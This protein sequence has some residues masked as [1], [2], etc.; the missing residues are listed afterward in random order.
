MKDADQY[1]ATGP[2][3][4][5]DFDEIIKAGDDLVIDMIDPKM[6]PRELRA[7][8]DPHIF[9]NEDGVE[10]LRSSG[11]AEVLGA[12]SKM[13]REYTNMDAARAQAYLVTSLGGQ[14]AD[15]SEGLR[16]NRG[17]SGVKFA[18]ER[19]RDNMQM[20][21]KLKGQTNYFKNQKAG[22][23]N[24]WERTRSLG[25]SDAQRLKDNFPIF[26]ENLN[27][28]IA[29]FGRDLDFI[30]KEYP[31][32]GDALAEMI[33][34]TDGRVFTLDA[35]NETMANS[36]KNFRPLFD[37]NPDTPNLIGSAVR[38]NVMNS[39]L[40]SMEVPLRAGYGN[41]AGTVFEPFNMMAGAMMRGDVKAIQDYWMAY[42]AFGDTLQKGANM[43]G[44][45]FTKG[46]S[47]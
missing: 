40:S 34:V 9:T 45:M 1:V 15:I 17:G 39:M 31:E 42:T 38:S 29:Q 32:L 27:L 7:M 12:T 23:I 24:M 35:L 2:G 47:E 46:I 33:E 5:V 36:F 10:M 30:F 26:Q 19:L 22:L 11:F 4:K 28:E 25:K 14:A 41:I 16:L 13:M 3:W 37:A 43:F 21:L 44:K 6:G 18:Q 20:L 8:L